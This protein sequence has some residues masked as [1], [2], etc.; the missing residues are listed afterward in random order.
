VTGRVAV[1]DSIGLL[2]PGVEL[3]RSSGVDVD[4]LPDGSPADRIMAAASRADVVLVGLTRFAAGD[5]AGLER[6]GLL[7]RCGIGYDVI[8]VAAAST[9]GI[10][11]ANVPDYCADE[12]ADHALLLLL[13]SARRL[14]HFASCWRS[15]AWVQ[16][17]DLPA[18]R[19]IAGRR[20]G[21][22]GL[23]RIGRR[24]AARAAAF[25]WE[26]V[27]HDPAVAAGPLGEVR[28]GLDELFATSDAVTLHCPL[29]A[30]TRHLVGPRLL[31]RARPGRVLV[32]TSRG[33][34]V[35]LAALEAAL[36]SGQ[37][38]G[39][40]LDVLE[41][42]PPPDPTRSLLRDPRVIVTPHVAWYSQEARRDL[43]LRSAEEAQ[44]F[45]RGERPLNVINRAARQ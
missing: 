6:P 42:E 8:D 20:L 29:T 3:L 27:Y 18:V 24:V 41:D 43:A 30:E 17:G 13:A 7:V 23:G 26:V 16:D 4:V 19:R 11:V 34:L 2:R 31:S 44:R 36:A 33:G 39:A 1:T 37:V 10:W 14:P 21:I 15:G 32:N 25:G 38:G 9:A 12:V 22:V 45:L 5:I 40:G 35:D 28:L